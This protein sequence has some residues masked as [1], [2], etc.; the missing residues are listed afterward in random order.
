M[1]ADSPLLHCCLILYNVLCMCVLFMLTL[2]VFVCLDDMLTPCD[3][4]DPMAAIATAPLLGEK[5][6][7]MINLVLVKNNEATVSH[8]YHPV[9]ILLLYC[10]TISLRLLLHGTLLFMMLLV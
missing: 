7:S 9:Y 2:R 10:V 6:E 5:D 1:C 3:D 8:P 4:E